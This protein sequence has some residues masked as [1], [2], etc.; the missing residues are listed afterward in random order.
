MK[1]FEYR[2]NYKKAIYDFLMNSNMLDDRKLEKQ[3]L[4]ELVKGKTCLEIGNIFGCSD[5]TIQRRRKSI[6]EKTKD[7]MC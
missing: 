2:F 5:R 3:I 1:N 4:R 6:Y 7:L